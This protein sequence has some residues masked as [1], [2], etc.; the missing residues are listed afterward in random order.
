M[1]TPK[2]SLSPSPSPSYPFLQEVLLDYTF[3]TVIAGG[4]LVIIMS[5]AFVWALLKAAEYPAPTSLVVSLSLLT[6]VSL[7]GSIVVGSR[8]LVT[9]AATGLGA[10]AGAVSS[11]FGDQR[12]KNPPVAEEEQPLAE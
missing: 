12:K 4:F 10:L 6:F 5:A 2:P 8:E 7:A 1:I 11:Q 9:L 3:I